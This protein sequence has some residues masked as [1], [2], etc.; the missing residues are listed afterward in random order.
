MTI[1]N[2]SNERATTYDVADNA[3]IRYEGQTIVLEDLKR[4]SYVTACLA[5]NEIIQ[6]ESFPSSSE[7]E[8]ALESITYGS[9]TVLTVRTAAGELITYSLNLSRLPD[10]YR[11]EKVSTI[12]RLLV[13]DDVVVTI[14][15]N[16]V[17]MIE[18]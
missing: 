5:N 13:G 15:Y 14:R 2:L 3:I 12:D 7:T 4:N 6:L 16:E 18:A 11:D 17:E 8:G 9:T 1:L 10:I